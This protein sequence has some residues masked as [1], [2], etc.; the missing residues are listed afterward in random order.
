MA[1]TYPARTYP[2]VAWTLT[3]GF[4]PKEVTLVSRAWSFSRD[5][6]STGGSNFVGD[7]AATRE[8]VIAM[9]RTRLAAQRIRLEKQMA[10][11]S[12]REAALNKAEG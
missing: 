7:L 4:K 12:K 10:T 5:V 2:Y 8:A 3:A 6:N 9:G 1:I 11:L